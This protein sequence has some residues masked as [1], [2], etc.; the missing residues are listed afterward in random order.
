MAKPAWL[1]ISP[2]SGSGNGAL[3]NTGNQNTGRKQRTGTV[4]VTGSGA[5]EPATYTVNQEPKP[6]FISFDEGAEL[7]A[8][9]GGEALKVTG[10]SNSEKLEF[11]FVGDA[12]EATLSE[13]YNAG[14]S[15]TNNGEAIDGDPGA[16]A[17]YA[18][19]VTIN[20]PENT[21]IDEVVRTLKVTNG[22]SISAQIQI[23]QT[24]GEPFITV[25]PKT[26]TLDWEGTEQTVQVKSNTTWTVS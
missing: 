1:T 5:S 3:K 26:I 2:M 24:A 17:E 16:T 21:T 11:S 19:D 6:E 14:G 12:K 13:Q 23:K 8:Q 25:E 4:T 7:S 18:F 15:P 20:I 22:A 9:K 10:K